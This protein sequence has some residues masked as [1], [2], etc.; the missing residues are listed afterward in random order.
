VWEVS[1]GEIIIEMP[2]TPPVVR[3]ELAGS[4]HVNGI[5]SVMTNT[6]SSNSIDLDDAS[7]WPSAGQF[8]LEPIEEIKTHI[9]TGSE[10]YV[11]NQSINGRFDV[12]GLRFSYA[13]KSGN[14][15][16]GITPDLPMQSGVYELDI[17]SIS[18]D[19]NN[20]VTVTTVTPFSFNTE[21]LNISGTGGTNLDGTHQVTEVLSS[22]QFRY[23]SVGPVETQST[24]LVRIERI[25]LKN[26]GSLVYL[27]SAQVNTGIFGP[28]LWDTKAPFILSS[29]TGKTVTDI[30]A[31]NIVLNLQINTPNNVP[32]ERG[33]L[34]FDYGLETQEGPVRYMY[35]AS[36]SIVALDP[37][38]VFQYDHQVG[39][40]I[41]AIRRKGAHVM[42]GLGKEYAFYVSDPSAARK[43]LQELMKQVKSVGTFIQFIVRY[44]TNY[45]SEYDLYSKTDDPLD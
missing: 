4:A 16:N 13:S 19:A 43:V 39:S 14:T 37:S 24:G 9:L 29:Y 33:F 27:T 7:D 34:I 10:D 20:I 6:N 32:N 11:S 12:V 44:P 1:P 8:V 38:Y 2:S 25:G 36:E 40:S 41:T 22:T 23:E 45:Y 21:A 15:L 35:K 31:G 17:A 18:R 3:R 26:E 5:T 42:S 30:K 28:N